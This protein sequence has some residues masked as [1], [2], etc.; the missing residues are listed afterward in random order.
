MDMVF[1]IAYG[2]FGYLLAKNRKG[3]CM[4]A[5]LSFVPS[6]SGY[7][8]VW[9]KSYSPSV[10][11]M[12]YDVPMW[13]FHVWGIMKMVAVCTGQYAFSVQNPWREV[14]AT[15]GEMNPYVIGEEARKRMAAKNILS[16][17]GNYM[18]D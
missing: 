2:T 1:G 17:D 7:A 13:I 11:K 3:D 6:F 10:S 4:S 8:G 15:K 12:L 16:K 9:D 14:F 5:M 18:Q